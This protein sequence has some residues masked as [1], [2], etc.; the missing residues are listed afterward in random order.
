MTTLNRRAIA[1]LATAIV[2][3]AGAGGAG[4][5]GD[6]EYQERRE[7]IE[8]LEP[9]KK[10]QLLEKQERF[11]K[12]PPEEQQKLRQLHLALQNEPNREELEQVM[13]AYFEWV[14]KL[15]PSER[16]QLNNESSP[17]E[18][19]KRIVRYKDSSNARRRR[20]GPGGNPWPSFSG[21]NPERMLVFRLVFERYD[22]LKSW[23][24]QFVADHASQLAGH[25]PNE[26][27][28]KWE[29]SVQ[30]AA[31]TEDGKERALWRALARWYLEAGPKGQLPLEEDDVENLKNQM[32][33][34]KTRNPLTDIPTDRLAPAINE[35]LRGIVR[36]QL[37]RGS[38]ELKDLITNAELAEHAREHP[39]IREGFP[40]ELADHMVRRHYIESRL[41]MNPFWP[42]GRSRGPGF[43]EGGPRRGGPSAPGHGPMGDFDRPFGD[44]QQRP[45]QPNRGKPPR[46]DRR[47]DPK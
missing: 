7:L 4:T 14:L 17:D 38:A 21:R 35:V 23:A 47:N 28:T 40:K 39:H 19:I 30:K 31:A 33:P 12:L 34:K 27:Q 10:K 2:I 6:Q 46:N 3:A 20:H 9:G 43:S 11:Q 41:G 36:E 15:Y 16:A 29:A 44:S 8:K 22:V 32:S 5:L 18:R 26:D 13:E 37:S 25:L 42:D 24:G 1:T 45:E